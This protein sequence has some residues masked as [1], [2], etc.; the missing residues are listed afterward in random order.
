[1]AL[2][3]MQEALVRIKEAKSELLY[4][5]GKPQPMAQIN[6]EALHTTA[7]AIISEVYAI[8]PVIYQVPVH[9]A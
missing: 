8:I 6:K 7:V 5:I 3:D 9:D 2:E 1:M 4:R